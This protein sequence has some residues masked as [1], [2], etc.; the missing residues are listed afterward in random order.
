MGLN[1]LESIDFIIA[2]L[3]NWKDKDVYKNK[4]FNNFFYIKKYVG[5]YQ[6]RKNV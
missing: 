3:F 2:F 5:C 6:N 1:I 4:N